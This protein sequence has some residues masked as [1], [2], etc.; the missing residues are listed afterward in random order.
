MDVLNT[1]SEIM[2]TLSDETVQDLMADIL[3]GKQTPVPDVVKLGGEYFAY[4]ELETIAA[5]AELD[6]DEMVCRVFPW[7]NE[8]IPPAVVDELRLLIH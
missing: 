3:A 6:A 5:A 4:T 7:G 2:D 1:D 8:A